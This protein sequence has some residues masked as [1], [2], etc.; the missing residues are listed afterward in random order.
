MVNPGVIA[1]EQPVQSP[2]DRVQPHGPLEEEA[3]LDDDPNR[4]V[5]FECLVVKVAAQQSSVWCSER[6][7]LTAEHDACIAPV[8]S[9][10]RLQDVARAMHL[11][12]HCGVVEDDDVGE[13]V[14]V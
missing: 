5:Y 1:H 7:L 6:R 3:G 10:H 9:M 11:Y 4:V 12:P 8:P 14:V 2:V 13:D